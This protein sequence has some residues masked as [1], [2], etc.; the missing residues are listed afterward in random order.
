MASL[1]QDYDLPKGAFP[2]RNT[3]F[4]VSPAKVKAVYTPA[5]HP[6]CSSFL[7]L[8]CSRHTVFRMREAPSRCLS[9]TRMR[10]AH[11]R[12]SSPFCFPDGR[13]GW[14]V[15]RSWAGSRLTTS[16]PTWAGT[17]SPTRQPARVRSSRPSWMRDTRLAKCL[18]PKLSFSTLTLPIGVSS[19]QADDV[20]GR[21]YHPRVQ[22]LSSL[23][24][25]V[26]G[27]VGVSGL[28]LK[29]STCGITHDGPRSSR[30]NL[31]HRSCMRDALL[32][33]LAAAGATR[34]VE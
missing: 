1:G 15:C 21:R 29:C 32:C 10:R 23:V 20:R 6:W 13:L 8:L 18:S 24:A 31:Q 12:V 26:D 16:R 17:T 3:D 14:G 25:D 30:W 19:G 11:G 4:Y 2:F 7:I 9:T 22:G 28:G 5:S 34:D 27:G 33:H